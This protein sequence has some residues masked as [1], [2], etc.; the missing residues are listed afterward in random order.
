MKKWLWVLSLVN[1]MSIGQFVVAQDGSNDM[2]KRR[3]KKANEIVQ[4]MRDE[5]AS[6]WDIKAQEKTNEEAFGHSGDEGQE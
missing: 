2:D 3:H 5:G 1:M 4:K 6:E